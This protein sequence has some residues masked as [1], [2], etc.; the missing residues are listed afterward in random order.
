MP[1]LPVRDRTLAMGLVFY[2]VCSVGMDVFKL[3]LGA[4]LSLFV[5]W[6]VCLHH[7]IRRSFLLDFFI[8]YLIR[9]N[10]DLKN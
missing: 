9:S 6:S 4:S 7:E 5:W 2:S 10:Q 1:L 8:L 3:R